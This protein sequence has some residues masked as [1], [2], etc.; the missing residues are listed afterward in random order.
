MRQL[1]TQTAKCSCQY[2]SFDENQWED[3]IRSNNVVELEDSERF[4]K[5]NTNP[6]ATFYGRP[7][8]LFYR[9]KHIKTLPGIATVLT[10]Y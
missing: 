2:F 9:C 8:L 3:F 10:I 5:K 6:R 7:T 1:Q 4:T